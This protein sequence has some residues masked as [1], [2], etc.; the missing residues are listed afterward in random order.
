M[1]C[2]FINVDLF[3]K[4]IGYECG[5]GSITAFDTCITYSDVTASLAADDVTSIHLTLK[6]D[7]NNSICGDIVIIDNNFYI[8]Y[9]CNSADVYIA[10]ES[11]TFYLFTYKRLINLMSDMYHVYD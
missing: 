9:H 3:L 4:I 5:L 10:T 6:D 2:N 1:N 8:S 11:D 7:C